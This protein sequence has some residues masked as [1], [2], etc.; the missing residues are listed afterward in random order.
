MRWIRE[1]DNARRGRMQ[2]WKTLSRSSEGNDI[3]GTAR[4][5]SP[6]GKGGGA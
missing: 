1:A 4:T 3:A 6:A 5:T 2:V